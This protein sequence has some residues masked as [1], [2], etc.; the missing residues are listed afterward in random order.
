MKQILKISFALFWLLLLMN[1]GKLTKGELLL[2]KEQ[3]EVPTVSATSTVEV[4]T[5]GSWTVATRGP[6]GFNIN[7]VTANPSSG[8]GRTTVNLTVKDNETFDERVAKVVFMGDYG[9]TASVKII[10]Q[11]R[12]V[13]PD[14]VAEIRVGNFNIRIS[15][16]EDYK[17][18]NGWDL[19]KEKVFAAVDKIDFDIFGFQEVSGKGN[20]GIVGDAMQ[21]DLCDNL[22]D[23]Y[24]FKFFSPYSE[25]GNGR[26]SN[27]FAYKRDKFTMSDYRFFW[28]SDT[29][30]IMERNDGSHN[31]GGCCAVF[32]H[33][34]TG[35]RFFFMESH[36][37][38]DK[39]INDNL[40]H[41]Y[42]DL[43]RLY[44]PDGLP[45]LFVGD[46]NNYPTSDAYQVYT[47]W[48]K[49][50]YATLLPYGKVTGPSGTFNGFN[51]AADMNTKG[52]IDY[53]FYRGEIEPL[54]YT[55]DDSLYDGHYPSDHL[56][57]Y[58]DFRIST[59][60]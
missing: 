43:E 25:D 9:K 17:T 56:P 59:K 44:N 22:G 8:K 23:E 24:E 29:P 40:A 6:S 45:S 3:I 30:N 27:G 12:S 51:T 60:E 32:T 19:R 50:A 11:G 16:D 21:T 33:K 35:I 39:T 28:I 55:C 4:D 41:V 7:W 42:P 34:E 38:L 36:A 49:D 5:Y 37:P 31:R 10:Q 52:R 58:C 20:G 15:A 57:I 47:A 54:H 26:S 13:D 1:C 14:A 18:G 2:D 48:W 53:I 46:L